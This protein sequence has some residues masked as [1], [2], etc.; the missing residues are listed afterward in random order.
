[1]ILQGDNQVDLLPSTVIIVNDYAYIN[2]GASKI[3]ILSARALAEAEIQV[4]FFYAVGPV[5]AI[6]IHKNI[7]LAECKQFDLISN[8]N[9]LSAM[10][11]GIWNYEAAKSFSLLLDNYSV[12]K[13]IV[14]FHVWVKALSSSVIRTALNKNFKVIITLHDYFTTCP[15][16]GF[17]NYQKNS[18]CELKP[19]SLACL[20]SHCDSRNR[21]Y[22]IWRIMRQ[23]IQK[24]VGDI[25]NGIKYFII[26]SRFSEN[27]LLQ[28]LPDD[29]TYCFVTN[30]I[31]VEN[32]PPA[33]VETNAIFSYIG[34]LSQEKGVLLL[35]RATHE[36]N[37][38]VQFIG[39]GELEKY[40]HQV[41]PQS[42]IHGWCD[43]KILE[44][45]Y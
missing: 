34:R 12:S 41:N 17:F 42:I 4:V 26:V 45:L 3:A 10:L 6:L 32:N 33:K 5:E 31:D 15:N 39:S 2:G 13:T 44:Q 29:A 37:A 1:M 43:I 40:I 7:K 9:K 30:P 24:I 38:P 19:L 14:H 22:K 27:I 21:F 23:F 28:Y 35:A 20:S 36:I 8:P 18:I 16:G 25:P 11:K